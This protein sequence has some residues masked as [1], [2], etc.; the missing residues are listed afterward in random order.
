MTEIYKLIE[1]YPNYE[2][3]NLGNVKS[4]NYRGSGKERLLIPSNKNIRDHNDYKQVFLF[5]ENGGKKFSVHRLVAL[6]FIPNPNGYTDVNHKDENPSN[7]RVEN[8][9]WC[10]H[11]YNLNYGTIK[12]KM[13]QSHKRKVVQL[14]KDGEVIRVFDSIKEAEEILKIS[15]ISGCCRGKYKT[16]G[17]YKWE[18]A[19]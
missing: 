18:Y 11:L 16:A 3:S 1:E 17:G 5:N 4:L 19:A 14:S 7:N 15:N 12:N 10:S 6:A 2:V 8:L 9:E 13:R